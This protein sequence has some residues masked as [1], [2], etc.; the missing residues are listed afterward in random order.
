M[1]NVYS[2]SGSHSD[3]CLLKCKV[4]VPGLWQNKIFWVVFKLIALLRELSIAWMGD[5]AF[6]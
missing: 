4:N 2:A 3:M 1:S 6:Q 5:D